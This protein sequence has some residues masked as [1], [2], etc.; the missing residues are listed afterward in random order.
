MRVSHKAR[1]IS[2]FD[3]LRQFSGPQHRHSVDHDRARFR[4]GEPAGDHR[5]IVRRADEH[6]IAGLDAIVLDERPGETIAPVGE[7]FVSTAPAMADEGGAV[8]EAALDHAIG[9][10]DRGVHVV[11][12]VK[13]VE[14]KVRPLVERRQIVA[15]ERVSVSGGTEHGFAPPLG[16]ASEAL[17]LRT[18]QSSRLYAPWVR[19]WVPAYGMQSLHRQMEIKEHKRE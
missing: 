13:P 15:R 6:A 3:D 4:R 1:P 9:E 10:L 11:R 16:A 12:V 19:A 8:S 14:P 2:A 7:L 18:C 17:A 5:G